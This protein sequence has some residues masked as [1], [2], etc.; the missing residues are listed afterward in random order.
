MPFF[1]RILF[2]AFLLANALTTNVLG[3]SID[4][5]GTLLDKKG[6][7]PMRMK[8]ISW[9]GSSVIVLA[10]ASDE[11]EGRSGGARSE[12][13]SSTRASEL[14]HGSPPYWHGAKVI[15]FSECTKRGGVHIGVRCLGPQGI[16]GKKGTVTRRLE[17]SSHQ[18]YTPQT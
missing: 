17:K 9:F 7:R 8:G 16:L 10:G 11:V 14:K 1:T 18:L 12:F 3:Y 2:A 6:S 5:T 4:N 15:R 13:P